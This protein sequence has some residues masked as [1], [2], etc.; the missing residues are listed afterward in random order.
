MPMIHT[1]KYEVVE[2]K[3][4]TKVINGK[5]VTRKRVRMEE[6]VIH[7]PDVKKIQVKKEPKPKKVDTFIPLF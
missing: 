6:I 4:V 5:E 1:G 3:Y 7:Q 2:T